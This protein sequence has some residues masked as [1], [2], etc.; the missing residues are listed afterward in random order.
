MKL[1]SLLSPLIQ[2]LTFSRGTITDR[3]RNIL[4]APWAALSPVKFAHKINHHIIFVP[5]GAHSPLNKQ[6]GRV[7]KPVGVCQ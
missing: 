7:T 6:V 3:P 2:I 1:I 4:L 5:K